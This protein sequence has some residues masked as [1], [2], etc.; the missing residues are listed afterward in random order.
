MKNPLICILILFLLAAGAT[1]DNDAGRE[2]PFS[3]GSG[4]RGLGMGGNLVGLPDGA[5]SIFWNPAALTSLNKKSFD[6]MYARL[7]SESH[8]GTAAMAYPLTP[9]CTMGGAVAYTGVGDIIKRVNWLD[10]GRFS[11]DHFQATIGIGYDMIADTLSD[12]SLGAS[13]NTQFQYLDNQSAT[14]FGGDLAV[15]YKPDFKLGILGKPSFGL[16]ARDINI[17]GLRLDDATDTYPVRVSAGMGLDGFRLPEE[18]KLRVHVSLEKQKGRNLKIHTGTETI[19]K[20]TFAVRFGYDHDRLACG[21]GINYKN[22]R[23]DY[24]LYPVNPLDDFDVWF[25]RFGLSVRWGK[26]PSDKLQERLEEEQARQYRNYRDRADDYF[27]EGNYDSSYV[28]YQRAL[29]LD[30]SDSH[31]QDRIGLIESIF[32]SQRKQESEEITRN[33]L[34][35][36]Y[37]REARRNLD[38]GNYALAQRFVQLARNI[39]PD[40]EQLKSLKESIDSTIER[41]ILELLEQARQAETD[42][43]LAEAIRRYNTILEMSPDD[44][45]YRDLEDRIGTRINLPSLISNGVEKYYSGD[46]VGARDDFEAVLQYAPDNAVARD[47]LVRIE[48]VLQQQ[49]TEPTTE[50]AVEPSSRI[51]DRSEEIQNDDQA[52]SLYTQALEKYDQGNYREAIDLWRRVLNLYPNDEK[53]LE[54]IR[55]AELR[56][57]SEGGP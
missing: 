14:G 30:A 8:Y 34:L 55:Q 27:A 4:V 19:Y 32:E 29:A 42:G 28:Y 56:L 17:K 10:Y 41:K 53:T 52:W 7:L 21:I 39:D 35:D 5:S 18:W 36:Q 20:N 40:D 15:F 44:E 12:L 38:R 11:Y 57:E 6:L 54:N 37:L 49:P 23:F 50:P 13:L 48:Q 47:Y 51:R 3:L 33:E 31:S 25:H 45:T 46:L 22:F 2:S 43:R 24:A 1:A 16:A 9:T 26:P